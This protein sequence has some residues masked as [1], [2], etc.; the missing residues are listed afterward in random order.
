MSLLAGENGMVRQE[1]VMRSSAKAV[2]AVDVG[3]SSVKILATAQTERRSFLSGP[4]LTPG[5]MVAA[6]KKLSA[7]WV[8]DVVSIGYP[9]PV[10]SD[11]PIAEPYNLGRGW[12]GFDF[13]EAFGCPVKV[14]N[15]AAMQAL[16]SYNGGKMLFS[17][18]KDVS[19]YLLISGAMPFQ[20][21]ASFG[22]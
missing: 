1:H 14:I 20:S 13:G 15:D 17:D 18:V 21:P 12:V 11:R 7:D 3:G 4:K 10:A 6:V 19:E 8:Y 22:I 16:G 5:R 9:G 2:L